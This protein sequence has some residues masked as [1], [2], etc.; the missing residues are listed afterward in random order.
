[1]LETQAVTP[2]Q[3]N[4][5]SCHNRVHVFLLPQCP[6]AMYVHLQSINRFTCHCQATHLLTP[7]QYNCSSWHSRVHVFLL[8]QCHLQSIN[9]STCRCQVN[10]LLSLV[11]YKCTTLDFIP[12]C[13]LLYK[14]RLS[15]I[16]VGV[17]RWFYIHVFESLRHL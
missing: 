10:N 14:H 11:C 9:H 6:S 5:S 1:M 15:F 3:Y 4:C 12:G 17:R 2:L 7:L 13:P 8:P 16:V